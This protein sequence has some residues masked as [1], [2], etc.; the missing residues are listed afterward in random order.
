MVLI[1]GPQ[2]TLA[3]FRKCASQGW[4]CILLAFWVRFKPSSTDFSQLNKRQQVVPA[5]GKVLTLTLLSNFSELCEQ[6]RYSNFQEEFVLNFATQ[7]ELRVDQT[8]DGSSRI[9]IGW[10]ANSN[11]QRYCFSSPSVIAFQLG[12]LVKS[13]R[14]SYWI[15][16]GSASASNAF[17]SASV[18][19]SVKSAISR[20]G[21]LGGKSHASQAEKPLSQGG[22]LQTSNCR[23]K[24]SHLC[25]CFR[26]SPSVRFWSKQSHT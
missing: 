13:V 22:Y 8:K 4:T 17:P 21:L 7:F 1:F 12:S 10:D 20:R 5:L 16:L 26:R 19:E 15:H 2:A 24:P 18:S 11:N 23:V 3:C 14:H 6:V 25:F 9:L